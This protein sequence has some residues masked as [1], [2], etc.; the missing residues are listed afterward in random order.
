MTVEVNTVYKKDCFELLGG[1]AD[2]VA[3]LIVL[4][5]NYQDW[6][7]LIEK[8]LVEET[9]RVLKKTGN[10][11]MFT[12]K[13]HDFN[14]R[15]K[16]NPV[17]RNEIIWKYKKNGNWYSYKMPIYTYQ[18]IYWCCNKGFFYN[19]QTGFPHGTEIS[20]AEFDYSNIG[21]DFNGY[22]EGEQLFSINYDYGGQWLKDLLDIPRK[23]EDG[24]TPTKPITLCQI[25]I[26]CF[27][28]VGGLVVDPFMGG[29]NFV[30]TAF[31]EQRDFV[32]CD[33]D[34]KCYLLSLEKTDDA[35]K[36]EQDRLK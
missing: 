15:N 32:G 35:K 19:P 18:K 7:N 30:V 9:F 26:R 12:K 36:R 17:F 23:R 14:L 33:I 11:L 4:D 8:G 25:L 31:N 34:E 20:Q 2:N 29:G 21:K 28:P 22:A 24:K 13:P 16:I 10:V 3:D 1:L 6:D 5:P 27:S